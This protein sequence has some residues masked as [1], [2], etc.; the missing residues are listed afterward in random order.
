MD[1]LEQYQHTIRENLLLAHKCPYE[2]S[3]Q[4][5][6]KYSDAVGALYSGGVAAIILIRWFYLEWRCS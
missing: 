2:F 4:M 1:S 5:L 3:D 6:E